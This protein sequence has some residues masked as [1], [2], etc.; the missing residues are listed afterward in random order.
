M[1]EEDEGNSPGSMEVHS[2][3]CRK[4]HGGI[5]EGSFHNRHMPRP[6][7]PTRASII[8]TMRARRLHY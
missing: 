4:T 8:S 2:A 3:R 7:N 6:R 5:G 1:V